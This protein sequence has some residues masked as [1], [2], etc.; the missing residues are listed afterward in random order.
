VDQPITTRGIAI[1]GTGETLSTGL[2]GSETRGIAFVRP[3]ATDGTGGNPDRMFILQRVPPAIVALDAATQTPFSV[4]EVCQGP[5]NL[6]QH[7][8]ATGRTVALFVTCFD[9]GEVYVIDPWVPRVRNVIAIG[10][11]PISTLLRSTT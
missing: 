6:T 8:D 9:A 7:R 1:V 5:T 10:R 2:A 11:G 4:T 3:G